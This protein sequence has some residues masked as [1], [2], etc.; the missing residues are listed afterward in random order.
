MRL[1]IPHYYDF[2]AQRERVGRDLA[3]SAA[4][5]TLR[6]GE[7]PFGL[8]STRAAW[9]AI[10]SDPATVARAE[11]VV[12]VARGCEARRLCS[13][14]VGTGAL[15]LQVA[16]HAPELE[17]TCTDY[18]PRAVTRL[19]E[20]F[21]E[22]TVVRHDLLADEPVEADLHLLHRVDTEF[23]DPD[24]RR[25]LL[26]FQEP[27]LLVPSAFLGG[28]LLLRELLVRF[29]RRRATRAGWLR[30]EDAFRALWRGAREATEVRI[31]ETRGYLLAR[32]GAAA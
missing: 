23:S 14:G 25:I 16:R 21:P 5:D 8:P 28:R 17:L 24:L 12:R 4:W 3:D 18:A 31:G 2:G 19:R 26:R 6:D 11:D 9:E 27:V 7:G 32:P 20:L 13:Y 1:T 10:A 30:S 22:A 15:E 29:G